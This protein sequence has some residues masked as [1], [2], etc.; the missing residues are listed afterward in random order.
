[1]RQLLEQLAD[2]YN[3]TREEATGIVDKVK[4]YLAANTAE[5]ATLQPVATTTQ[6]NEVKAQVKEESMLEK[7]GHFVTDHLPGGMKEK[8]EEMIGQAES[9]IKGLFS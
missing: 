9:K 1:M 5:P 2:E 4:N 7:A 3:L 6:A 8:A